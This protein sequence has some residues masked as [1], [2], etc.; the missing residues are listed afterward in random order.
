M[1]PRRGGGGLKLAAGLAALGLLVSGPAWALPRG[2]RPAVV[3]S[4]SLTHEDGALRPVCRPLIAGE[5]DACLRLRTGP[6]ERWVLPGDLRQWGVEAEVAWAGVERLA[7]R[8]LRGAM[9]Q[10]AVEGM[11]ASY[12]LADR[13]DGWAGAVLLRPD[14]AVRWLGPELRVAAPSFDVVLAWTPSAPELDLIMAVGVHDM[15]EQQ[16][17]PVH[18][19]VFRTGPGGW[20]LFGAARRVTE[21]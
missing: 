13:G 18:D 16:A 6:E 7:G 10:V 19:G 8:R 9:R 17:G 1:G 3:R 20:A 14:L 4:G 21:P 5:L 11:D 15:Y 12:W 2:V